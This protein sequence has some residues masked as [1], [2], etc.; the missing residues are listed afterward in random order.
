MEYQL[1]VLHVVS[2]ALFVKAI[3]NFAKHA[4]KDM[5]LFEIKMANKLVNVG[6]V[7][8]IVLNVIMILQNAIIASMDSL[9]MKM[10]IQQANVINA[11]KNVLIAILIMKSVIHVLMDMDM[12]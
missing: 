3:I 12:F 2:I 10:D 1:F 6:V 11:Q 4:H 7:L 8:M 9:L 5:D